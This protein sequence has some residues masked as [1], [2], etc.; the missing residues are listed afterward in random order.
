MKIAAIALCTGLLI[1]AQNQT[2]SSEPRAEQS[3]FSLQVAESKLV[4]N[5]FAFIEKNRE[6]AIAEWISLTEIPAPS[7][8]EEKRAAVL[9]DKFAAAGLENVRIDASGNV[10][11][12]WRDSNFLFHVVCDHV[13]ISVKIA[14][15]LAKK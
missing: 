2:L 8:K 7:G 14:T 13:P 11:G 4:R 12:V 15:P 9:R 6:A 5:A 3:R 1:M 10:I